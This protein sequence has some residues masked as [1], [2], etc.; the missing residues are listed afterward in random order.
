MQMNPRGIVTLV[1]HGQTSANIDQVWHGS[2]DTPLTPFGAL[3]AQRVAR[4]LD[5]HSGDATVVYSSPLTRARHTAEPIAQQL[6]LEVRIEEEAQGELFESFPITK[7]SLH[8]L[9]AQLF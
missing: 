1:R 8:K 9:Y 2:S 4:F 3:Q 7:V 6:G 5:G